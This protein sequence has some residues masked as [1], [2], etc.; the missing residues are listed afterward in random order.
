MTSEF[1]R[2]IISKNARASSR[3][4]RDRDYKLGQ[5]T[6]VCMCVYTVVQS[7]S[8]FKRMRRFLIRFGIRYLYDDR[9]FFYIREFVRW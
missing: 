8:K 5:C 6:I 2:S 7:Q 4:Y 3:Y 9:S 1:T